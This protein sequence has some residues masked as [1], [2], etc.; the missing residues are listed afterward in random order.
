MKTFLDDTGRIVL[1]GLMQAQLGVKP[2]DELTLEE[3]NGKWFIQP[4]KAAPE[5]GQRFPGR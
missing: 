2:G 1:P 5:D 3:K 4:V